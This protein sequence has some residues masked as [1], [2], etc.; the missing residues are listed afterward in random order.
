MWR[1]IASPPGNSIPAYNVDGSPNEAGS[2]MEI[3]DAILHLDG[4]SERTA[5]A[6]TSL[7]KQEIILGFTWLAEHNLEID[8]QPRR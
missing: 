1:K 5:F 6:A 2:I 7:G 8:W 4:H 3:V